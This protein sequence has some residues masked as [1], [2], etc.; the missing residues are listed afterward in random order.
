M[1]LNLALTLSVALTCLATNV[2]FAAQSDTVSDIEDSSHL[3]GTS[4]ASAEVLTFTSLDGVSTAKTGLYDMNKTTD[5]L[6]GS[7]KVT[8][9]IKNNDSASTKD[10]RQLIDGHLSHTERTLRT[11][12]GLN[13]E[14]NQIS[15]QRDLQDSIPPL[16]LRRDIAC[17]MGY[18]LVDTPDGLNGDLNQGAGNFKTERQR[19]IYLCST[20]LAGVWGAPLHAVKLQPSR[21]C[22]QGWMT[23]PVQANRMNGDL[24]QFVGGKDIFLC[25]ST[26]PSHGARITEIELVQRRPLPEQQ[27]EIIAPLNGDLNQSAGGKDIYLKLCVAYGQNKES[28]MAVSRWIKNFKCVH[29]Y[30]KI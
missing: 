12:S 7:S 3:R 10:G 6:P 28:Y 27:P 16:Q 23:T 29:G 26:N 11:A 25:Y 20:D 13:V 30:P 9:S 17:P 18:A 24:N 14:S 21:D 8:G 4:S 1:N 22:G 19:V 5:S 2:V 15:S